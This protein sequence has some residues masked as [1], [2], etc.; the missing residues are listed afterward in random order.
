MSWLCRER[1]PSGTATRLVC[2]GCYC[3]RS[4]LRSPAVL[5]P[6]CEERVDRRQQWWVA[7]YCQTVKRCLTTS[8]VLV[9]QQVRWCD[10]LHNSY[11]LQ[12]RQTTCYFYTSVDDAG[13]AAVSR[14]RWLVLCLG[15][16]L[17]PTHSLMNVVTMAL[18]STTA[19]CWLESM[20][21][22]SVHVWVEPTFL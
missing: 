5:H 16:T 19:C 6:A 20:N 1:K 22:V 2:C 21:R 13:T 12:Q 4:K 3:S 11:I 7:N 10:R 9:M 17:N 8:A 14:T 18:L 15:G